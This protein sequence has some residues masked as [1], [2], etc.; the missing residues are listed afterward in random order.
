[1]ALVQDDLGRYIFR[2]PTECPCLLPKSD[3]LS[4]AKVHLTEKGIFCLVYIVR[5]GLKELLCCQT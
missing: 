2:G 3:L 1:M 5:F 4:K